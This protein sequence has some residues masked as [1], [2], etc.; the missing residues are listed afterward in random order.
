MFKLT[1]LNLNGIRSATTKGLEKWLATHAPDCI[2]VQEVKCQASDVEGRFEQ[3][4]GLKG[5]FHFAQKK[6]YSGTGI[7]TRHEPSDVVIGFG[8]REFDDEGRFTELRFDTPQRKLS[9]LSVYFPSGSSGPERQDAKYRFLADFYPHLQSLK[10]GREFIL[11]GDVNIAHQEKD[12][13]N[14]RSNQKNSGFLPEERAWMTTLLDAGGMVD[15]YR[16]LQPDTTDACYTWWSN[17]G[18]AYANNV[19]WRLDYHLA[20]PA[21]AA[22]ARTESI[23][24]TEK[25]SDHAPISIDYDFQL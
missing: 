1:S 24:K 10:N 15:V 2:C 18:Q 17:R 23:Y 6:G 16:R 4:A 19:G 11:C 5:H 14:W 8:S 7:F 21:L 25:F 12:L 9:I 20:T 22:L 13:K 3:L